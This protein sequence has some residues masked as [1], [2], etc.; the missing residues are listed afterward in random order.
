M[1]Q[2]RSIMTPLGF[3]FLIIFVFL[4]FGRICDFYL[5]GLHLALV[6]STFALVAAFFSGGLL[7]AARSRIGAAL[8]LYTAW[9]LIA[10][11]FSGWR[12]GSFHTVTDDWF[13]SLATFFLV[14]ALTVTLSQTV[15]LMRTIAY[16]MLV[17]AGLALVFSARTAGR[18]AHAQGQYSGPNELAS[19][20][21][22]GCIY[23]WFVIFNPAHS[24]PRK[25]VGAVTVVPLFYVMIQTGSRAS[26][27]A[28]AVVGV[29]LLKYFVPTQRLFLVLFMVGGF[30]VLS[31]T[32]PRDV[33]VRYFTL[34]SSATEDITSAKELEQRV[35]TAGSSNTRLY[36][37]MTSLYFTA[38]HPLFGVGPGQ[39]EVA[40]NVY[41]NREGKPRGLWLGTH[42]TYT[43]ISCEAGIPAVAFFLFC[44]FS[45]R[46]ELRAVEKRCKSLPRTDKIKEIVIVGF[47]LK[48]VLLAYAVF[49]M[50][51]HI[52]Y[53]AF[54]PALAGLVVAFGRAARWELSQMEAAAAAAAV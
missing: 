25:L 4:M 1:P 27:I 22:L 46:R 29:F 45:C 41:A 34:F 40:E 11:P 23:S 13:K 48:M 38:T 16:S 24:W 51:E 53:T 47:T 32:I 30:G 15:K 36:M 14:A 50:F 6:F 9:L 8:L 35:M 26:L 2:A 31:L 54:L 49:F 28:L 43:Q 33:R 18:L 21:M 10:V 52:G 5:V 37:L 20:M 3:G 17:A 19:A 42:N 39:F 7:M 44:M 12:G